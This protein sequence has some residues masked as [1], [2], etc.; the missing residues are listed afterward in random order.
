MSKSLEK[1]DFEKAEA[2]A[3]AV[4]DKLKGTA[5]ENDCVLLLNRTKVL[6][7][8]HVK[9]VESIEGSSVKKALPESVSK[10]GKCYAAGA[11]MDTLLVDFGEIQQP[12]KWGSMEKKVVI[13][14]YATFLDRRFRTNRDMLRHFARQFKLQDS[15]YYK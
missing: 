11:S 14:I 5:A 12:L 6:H 3:Q 8:L 9:V 10:I 4:S 7:Q 2:A 15:E 1:F 13:E